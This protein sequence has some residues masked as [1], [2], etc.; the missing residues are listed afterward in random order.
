MATWV[1]GKTAALWWESSRSCDFEQACSEATD[2]VSPIFSAGFSGFSIA[3]RCWSVERRRVSTRC[4]AGP[5]SFQM[6]Y[7]CYWNKGLSWTRTRFRVWI[8]KRSGVESCFTETSCRRKTLRHNLIRFFYECNFQVPNLTATVFE[9]A[10]SS[11]Y[12]HVAIKFLCWQNQFRENDIGPNVFFIKYTIF[13]LFMNT[14]CY[15]NSCYMFNEYHFM[16]SREKSG[17]KS[18]TAANSRCKSDI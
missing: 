3:R 16:I 18:S 2:I 10:N 9:R 1:S 6:Y 4:V 17:G 12:C 8:R 7:K 5:G 14:I 11:T 13:M 15:L